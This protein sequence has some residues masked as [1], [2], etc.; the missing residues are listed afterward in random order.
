MARARSA[1]RPRERD[2]LF[3]ASVLSA[4]LHVAVFVAAFVVWPYVAP[5]MSLPSDIVPVELL[6]PGEETNV[7]PQEKAEEPPPEPQ[8]MAMPELP[9]PPP[10]DF[11][12]PPPPPIEDEAPALE[13]EEKPEETKPEP[14]PQ[15]PQQRFAMA[16]PRAKPKPEKK[17]EE[18]DVDKILSSIDQ[19]EKQQAKADVKAPPKA[20]DRTLQAAGAQTGLSA[21]EIAI[22]KGKLAKC[23]NVPVGAP[24][25]SALVFRV[26]FSLNEDG[27]VASMPQLLD[28][29]RLGDP[30][31]RAAADAAIRAIQICGPYDLP[32]EK[33]AGAGGW[34]EITVEF[35]PR[36]MAGY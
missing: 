33:Y 27:T 34:N 23:W 13:P 1:N 28:Q 35:D 11:E 2:S 9:P 5:P 14:K 26:R 4:A 21:N 24:D 15:P 22:L 25:P 10:P 29:G 19:V 20:A 16:T 32:P 6:D 31:F 17:K 8:Q 30:Y 36:K 18:F 3:G 7:A 12:E